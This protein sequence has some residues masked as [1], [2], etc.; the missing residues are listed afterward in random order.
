[1]RQENRDLCDRLGLNAIEIPVFLAMNVAV[2]AAAY[3][4]RDPLKKRL[5]INYLSNHGHLLSSNRLLFYHCHIQGWW[6]SH[7]LAP[8]R[9]AVCAHAFADHPHDARA[10]S[11]HLFG[12]LVISA[13][14]EEKTDDALFPGRH[15]RNRTGSAIGSAPDNCRFR[16]SLIEEAWFRLSGCGLVY[17]GF[18]C[19]RRGFQ[20]NPK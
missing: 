5:L 13:S 4:H 16:S 14:I 17:A 12:N 20:E 6:I 18:N 7:S 8:E 3:C 15:H 19:R 10:P 9:N 11:L 1:M 2:L